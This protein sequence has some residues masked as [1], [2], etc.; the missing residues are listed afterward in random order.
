M[1]RWAFDCA[2]DCASVFATMNSTPSS[3]AEI[4]LLTALPPAPPTP[5]TVMR[6]LN[7]VTSGTFNFM[8]MFVLQS[9]FR[10]D[11]AQRIILLLLNHFVRFAPSAFRLICPQPLARA[12]PKR[13]A[14]RRLSKV[15]RAGPGGASSEL[16]I[17]GAIVAPAIRR[18]IAVA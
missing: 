11:V 14:V 8:V 2:R 7:S 3:L 15:R 1:R 5:S 10:P 16:I 18:P 12:H 9:W 13:P 4:I 17:S 6:G